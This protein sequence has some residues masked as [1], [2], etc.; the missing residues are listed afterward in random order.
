VKVDPAIAA[1]GEKQL[2][3]AAAEELAQAAAAKD[4]E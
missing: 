3:K 4:A 2:A 1:E